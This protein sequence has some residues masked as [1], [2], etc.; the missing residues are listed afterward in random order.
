MDRVEREVKK[1]GQDVKAAAKGVGRL[2][3][4]AIEEINP[5]A[6][7]KR[8]HQ[9]PSLPTN[10]DADDDNF[11]FEPPREARKASRREPIEPAEDAFDEPLEPVRP[12]KQVVQQSEPEQTDPFADEPLETN[13]RPNQ[14]KETRKPER[15]AKAQDGFFDDRSARDSRNAP[16]ELNADRFSARE[17]PRRVREFEDDFNSTRIESKRSNERFATEV[18]QSPRRYGLQDERTYVVQPNDNFW[19]ISRNRYGAGR[20]YAALALH[21]RQTIAD[22]KMMKPGMVISTPDPAELEQR[23]PEAIPKVAASV[24]SAQPVSA[25]QSRRSA[26]E[27]PAGYFLAEDGTPMYRIGTRDTLTEIARAHLGRT[28]RWVQI[29]EMNRNVLRDGN[30]LKIG[31][32]LRL[33]SD[34]SRVQVVDRPREFR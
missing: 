7:D 27:G 3:S 18:T 19:T 8:P 5:F 9:K 1:V 24:D 13:A 28:S 31:T 20:Y 2:A 16:A 6:S 10:L 12:R 11:A 23:Y 22:P 25:T 21:N 14:F 33:P 26:D 34:A 17:E 4:D 29:L 30:E 32:V 15:T